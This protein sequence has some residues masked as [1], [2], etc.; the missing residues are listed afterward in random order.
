MKRAEAL[1]AP[2]GAGTGKAPLAHPGSTCSAESQVAGAETWPPA[3]RG[4]QGPQGR[5]QAQ[6]PLPMRFPPVCLGLPP[7][8]SF[9]SAPWPSPTSL[10]PE[11][12][13]RCV[14]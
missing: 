10:H 14:P 11:P 6:R 5:V 3:L 2:A 9:P 1:E 7:S 12:N 8:S 13:L 4:P